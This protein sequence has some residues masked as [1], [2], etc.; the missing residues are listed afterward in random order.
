MVLEVAQVWGV[1]LHIAHRCATSLPSGEGPGLV[2]GVQAAGQDVCL[3]M[4][5]GEVGA[6]RWCGGGQCDPRSARASIGWSVCMSAAVVALDSWGNLGACGIPPSVQ[7]SCSSA[8]ASY[9]HG[10]S[11]GLRMEVLRLDGGIECTVAHRRRIYAEYQR[12]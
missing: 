6:A 10:C 1:P 7:V 2:R 3:H 12:L 11:V 9:P 5:C 4:V 8:T